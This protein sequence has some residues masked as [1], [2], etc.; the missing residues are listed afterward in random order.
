MS[1]VD[2]SETGARLGGP[3]LPALGEYL[4]IRIEEIHVFGTVK[5]ARDG[6]CG[7]EFDEPIPPDGLCSLRRCGT[8][9]GFT[10]LSVSE[11]LALDEWLIGSGR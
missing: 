7:L 3:D 5:W 2:V 8:S 11:K 4:Q 6:A 1:L 10:R 9:A